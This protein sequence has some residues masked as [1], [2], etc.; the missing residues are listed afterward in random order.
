MEKLP[1]ILSESPHFYIYKLSMLLRREFLMALKKYQLTPEKWQILTAVW[2][3]VHPVN[4]ISLARITSKDKPSISRLII[5]MEKKGWIVREINPIDMRAYLIK[6]TPKSFELKDSIIKD[7]FSHFNLLSENFGSE[8]IN[9]L[10]KLSE[11][12]ISI[13]E[14]FQKIK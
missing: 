10:K 5:G 3:N 4:Q 11:E 1:N 13:I 7:L 9:Q 14:S 8:K 2:E 6:A 12:Y